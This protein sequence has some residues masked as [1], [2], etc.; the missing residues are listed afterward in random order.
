MFCCLDTTLLLSAAADNNGGGH[1][2]HNRHQRHQHEHRAHHGRHAALL[3]D[4]ELA[5]VGGLLDLASDLQDGAMQ[6]G[7]GLPTAAPG[8]SAV[9]ILA[10]EPGAWVKDS[11]KRHRRQQQRAVLLRGGPA[12]AQDLGMSPQQQQQLLQGK[13]AVKQAPAPAGKAKHRPRGSRRLLSHLLQ[14]Q[15]WRCTNMK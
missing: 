3:D 1:R 6:Y 14:T 8:S 2:Q 9:D 4:N 11:P 15:M 5:W 12:A 7:L 13:Q 10:N